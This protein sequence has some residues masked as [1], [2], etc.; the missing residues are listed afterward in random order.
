M[1]GVTKQNIHHRNDEVSRCCVLSLRYVNRIFKT[2]LKI[3]YFKNLVYIF[4]FTFDYNRAS[5]A[6]F[7]I[8]V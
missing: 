3:K 8:A 6:A 4:H 5:L 1:K 7:N 2:S